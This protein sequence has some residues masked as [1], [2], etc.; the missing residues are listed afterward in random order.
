VFNE[1]QELKTVENDFSSASNEKSE[2]QSQGESSVN[3]SDSF[4][5]HVIADNDTEQKLEPAEEDQEHSITAT[6]QDKFESKHDKS[7][8]YTTISHKDDFSEDEETQEWTDEKV[9]VHVAYED[10]NKQSE[11]PLTDQV[12]RHEIV[13][14]E[15]N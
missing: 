4:E 6:D 10:E 12:I 11:T 1:I 9:E 15:K 13:E 3:N 2:S 7:S 5:S 8:D 14:D